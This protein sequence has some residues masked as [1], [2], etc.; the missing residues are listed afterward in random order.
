M[1]YYVWVLNSS[2]FH[3]E[4]YCIVSDISA[5]EGTQQ[6][7]HLALTVDIQAVVKLGFN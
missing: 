6:Q 3:E 1:L 7:L 5:P 4:S 2:T